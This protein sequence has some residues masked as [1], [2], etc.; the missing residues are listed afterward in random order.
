MEK[1]K[2]ALKRLDFSSVSYSFHIDGKES[3]KTYF[4]G[5]LYLCYFVFFVYFVSSMSINFLGKL[6]YSVVFIDRILPTPPQ[7]PLKR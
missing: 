7:I 2:K 3:F 6:N 1:I 4:G 5:F